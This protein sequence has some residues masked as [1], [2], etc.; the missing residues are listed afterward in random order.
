MSEKILKF[1]ARG[2]VWNIRSVLAYLVDRS[3]V[4]D[5]IGYGELK[6]FYKESAGICLMV[7]KLEKS[8]LIQRS[9]KSVR[10]KNNVTR[11]GVISF[12][13]KPRLQAALEE[14]DT[15]IERRA[16]VYEPQKIRKAARVIAKTECAENLDFMIDVLT[17]QKNKLWH[18]LR[19]V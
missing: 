6:E 18:E 11:A 10:H 8:G 12:H 19:N 5:S 4:V 3:K 16:I 2:P 1:G 13:D 15:E 7:R 14:L 9:F 17:S